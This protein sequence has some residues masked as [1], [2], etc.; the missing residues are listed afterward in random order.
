MQPAMVGRR[1]SARRWTPIALAGV[2]FAATVG[3]SVWVAIGAVAIVGLWLAVSIVE[4]RFDTRCRYC[5]EQALLPLVL[6]APHLIDLSANRDFGAFPIAFRVRFFALAGAIS[7]VIGGGESIIRLMLLPLN[8]FWEAPL[9][10]I[11]AALF[12]QR[13]PDCGYPW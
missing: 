7:G 4:R 10:V 3:L 13:P 5:R 6:I 8:Y 11:G 2:A 9:L 12:W 1:C